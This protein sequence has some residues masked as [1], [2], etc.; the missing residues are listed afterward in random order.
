MNAI[1]YTRFSPRP[2]KDGDAERIA[3]NE[4][5]ESIRLQVGSAIVTP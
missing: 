1:I 3:A 2:V 4:D 5:A